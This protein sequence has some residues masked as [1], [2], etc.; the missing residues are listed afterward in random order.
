MGLIV[1]REIRSERLGAQYAAIQ[2]RVSPDLLPA[3]GLP[4]CGHQ[5][6]ILRLVA[7]ISNRGRTWGKA[8]S[9]AKL[10]GMPLDLCYHAAW[11]GP[12]FGPIP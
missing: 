7:Q 5:T 2:R 1:P 11:L 6:F 8:D 12:Y 9:R 10:A 4:G 3:A